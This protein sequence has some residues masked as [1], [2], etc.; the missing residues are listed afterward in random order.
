MQPTFAIGLSFSARSAR[1]ATGADLIL[2]LEDGALVEAG[3]HQQLLAR[4]GIY[5]TLVAAQLG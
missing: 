2:T 3:T 5:A 1:H 4:E